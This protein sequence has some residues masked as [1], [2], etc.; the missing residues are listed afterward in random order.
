MRIDDAHLDSRFSLDN[1]HR[2]RKI[3]VVAHDDRVVTSFLEG[4]QEQIRREINIGSLLLGLQYFYGSSAAWTR[5][6]QG[7]TRLSCHGVAVVNLDEGQRAQCA[8]AHF[9]LLLLGRLAWVS[10]SGAD[11]DG[12]VTD[13]NDQASDHEA[14]AESFIVEPVVGGY[15]CIAVA[16]VESIDLADLGHLALIRRCGDR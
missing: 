10:M 16:E 2:L 13:H 11:P 6:G 12:E 3:G 4:I 9:L 7:H 15:L 5:I 8:Q 1:R 14:M